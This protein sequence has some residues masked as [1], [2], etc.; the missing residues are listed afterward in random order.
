M[1]RVIPGPD[2][3]RYPHGNSLLVCGTSETILIDPSLTIAADPPPGVDRVLVSHCHEDHL[4]GL[5]RYP[6]A[7]VHVHRDDHLGLQ[8]L[9]G[10][11]TIYGLPSEIDAAW[12][13][14]VVEKYHYAPRPDALV[15]EDGDRFDV[16][17]ATV[18]AIHLPG[19]TR[20]H[21]GFLVEPDGVM[22]LADIDLTGFGP[23]YGDAW[24]SLDD[25]ERSIQ[26]CREIDAGTYV[27][28]HHRGTVHGRAELFALLDA[29]EEVIGRREQAMRRFLEQPRTLD[30]MVAHRFIYR[31][32]VT[33]LF[34]DAVERRSA[35][36]HLERL[37][38]RG[39]VTQPDLAR[40]VVSPG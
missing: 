40:Y 10:L 8:S 19:H 29:Y 25:F 26:R 12:R 3:G 1:T 15:F 13:R 21:S 27:T 7:A 9:D 20:G 37:L 28:F 23:Y 34:A 16:G 18:R 30:E 14:D 33:L 38:R 17:G 31:P 11:M 22:F 4:A 5:F 6:H 24:S 32:H 39:L 35:E 2:N 36:L